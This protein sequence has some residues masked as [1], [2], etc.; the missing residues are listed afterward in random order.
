MSSG[1]PRTFERIFSKPEESA[2]ATDRPSKPETPGA[3]DWTHSKFSRVNTGGTL[4]GYV[5]FVKT[6]AKGVQIRSRAFLNLGVSQ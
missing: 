5:F 3:K 1:R 4:F 2:S 6:E